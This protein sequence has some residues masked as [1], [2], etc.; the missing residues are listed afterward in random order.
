MKIGIKRGLI[1][2]RINIRAGLVITISIVLERREAVN[3]ILEEVI[4]GLISII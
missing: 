2:R 3:K 4:R 1:T